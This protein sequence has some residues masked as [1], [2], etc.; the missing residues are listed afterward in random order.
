MVVSTCGFITSYPT[1]DK[2]E[3]CQHITISNEHD[4]YS[5]KHIFNI[6][7][8]KEEQSRNVFNLR[9][10]NKMGSQ[11]PCAPPVTYIQDDMVIHE[12]NRCMFNVSVRLSQYLIVNRLIGK[13][14]VSMT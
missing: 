7:P 3:T 14:R 12:F 5:S 4:W 8:M 10:I 13:I 1:D 6:P 11:T 2:I 9:S